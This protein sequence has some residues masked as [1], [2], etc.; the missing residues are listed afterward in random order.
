MPTAM[1]EVSLTE[2]DRQSLTAAKFKAYDG[3]LRRPFQP[4]EVDDACRDIYATPSAS[5]DPADSTCEA[6]LE[7]E[8]TPFPT[9]CLPG[10][11]GDMAREIGRVTTAQNEPLAAASVIAILSAAIGAGIEVGE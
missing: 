11:A 10:A 4:T 2:T 1:N 3:T 7:E 9:H 5:A 8:L 6:E